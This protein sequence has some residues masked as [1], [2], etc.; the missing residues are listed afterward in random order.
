MEIGLDRCRIQAIRKGY[1]E[2][3]AEHSNDDLHIHI[4]IETDFY[5]DLGILQEIHARVADLN[6][7]LLSELPQ[8][9]KLMLKSH[10]SEKK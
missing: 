2:P 6:N 4:M 8:R 1:H 9:V 7:S 10:L 3:H 5:E